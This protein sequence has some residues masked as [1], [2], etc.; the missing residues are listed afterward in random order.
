[1]KTTAASMGSLVAVAFALGWGQPHARAASGTLHTSTLTFADSGTASLAF[2][3]RTDIAAGADGTSIQLEFTTDGN[4]AAVSTEPFPT[5]ASVTFSLSFGGTAIAGFTCNAL[6]AVTGC[7]APPGSPNVDVLLTKQ[8]SSFGRYTL[9]LSYPAGSSGLTAPW[10]LGIGGIPTS[11]AGIR[12]MASIVNGAFQAPL[13]PT[14]ACG[15]GAA[16]CPAGQS[17]KGPCIFGICQLHPQICKAIWWPIWLPW[18]RVGPPC[19]SCPIEWQGTF[20][21]EFERVVLSFAAFGREGAP[22]GAGRA[23]EIE[24]KIEGGSA[25]GG[26]VDLGEGQYAQMIESR[27]GE[28]S[29]RV[30]ATIAGVAT[31]GFVAGSTVG[32]ARSPLTTVLTVL[33]AIALAV[34]AYLARRGRAATS[35]Q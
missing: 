35:A 21:E 31:P 10:V 33:L 22:L 27:R 29:P 7:H 14:G 3:V 8:G 23:K 30:T 24:L 17:C 34:V 25:I 4:G 26:L 1:M 15:T 11:P 5:P 19:L 9:T 2:N 16:T 28:P 32:A 18:P 12:G 20:G 6:T 13:A